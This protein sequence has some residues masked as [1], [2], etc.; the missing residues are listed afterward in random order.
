MAYRELASVEM[1]WAYG[2]RDLF[3]FDFTKFL[4]EDEDLWT[5]IQ[6]ALRLSVSCRHCL[7]KMLLFAVSPNIFSRPYQRI[8]LISYT[9]ALFSKGSS[10]I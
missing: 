2:F 4:M 6:L 3:W 9:G 8:N 10:M 7:P 1:D 5:L